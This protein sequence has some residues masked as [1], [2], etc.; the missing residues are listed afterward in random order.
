MQSIENGKCYQMFTRRTEFLLMQ[1]EVLASGSVKV[2]K[3]NRISTYVEGIGRKVKI[4]SLQKKQNFY[5]CRVSEF[6][7]IL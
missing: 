4:S 2:Y 7:M 5:L 6:N 1:S 3:K